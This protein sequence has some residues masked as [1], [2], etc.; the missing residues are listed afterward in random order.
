MLEQSWRFAEV[1]CSLNSQGMTYDVGVLVSGTCVEEY[2]AV[3]GLQE[4]VGK[5]VA[6]G[7]GGRCSFR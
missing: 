1:C 7:C 4:A 3:G 5:Q 6:V 2:D